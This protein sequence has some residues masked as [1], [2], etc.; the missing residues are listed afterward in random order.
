[1]NLLFLFERLLLPRLGPGLR[2]HDFLPLRRPR[3][4]LLDLD[5]LDLLDLLD[6]D[7]LDLFIFLPGLDLHPLRMVFLRPYLHDLRLIA[8]FFIKGGAN[9]GHGP[10]GVVGGG[11][12]DHGDAVRP[13]PFI[14]HGVEI[15]G[16]SQF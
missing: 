3:L 8:I 5:F 1:M 9:I 12:N 13:V 10:G 11:F 4:H 6:L 2:L 14:K 16:I 7:F 15:F